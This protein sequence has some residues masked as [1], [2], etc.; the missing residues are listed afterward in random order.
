MNR[1]TVIAYDYQAKGASD[2]VAGRKDD[3]LYGN[4]E[5][6]GASYRRGWQQARRDAEASQDPSPAPGTTPEAIA[7]RIADDQNLAEEMHL[8]EE[9]NGT[10]GSRSIIVEGAAPIKKGAL[11]VLDPEGKAWPHVAKKAEP[12]TAEQV[13]LQTGEDK[14]KKPKPSDPDQLAFF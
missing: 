13:R 9:W 10:P 12:V 7:A 11:V 5:N 8:P 14:P 4:P 2:F 3:R 6:H 1:E